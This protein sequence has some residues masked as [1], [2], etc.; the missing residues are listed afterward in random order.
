MPHLESV[1]H[2]PQPIL[3]HPASIMPHLESNQQHSKLGSGN[4]ASTSMYLLNPQE[5]SDVREVLQYSDSTQQNSFFDSSNPVQT[6]LW[7]KSAA[8]NLKGTEE[9]SVSTRNHSISRPIPRH[10]SIAVQ[11]SLSN[12]A[13]VKSPQLVQEHSES[14]PQDLAPPQHHPVSDSQH[15]ITTSYNSELAPQNLVPSQ[16]HLTSDSQFS[17]TILQHPQSTLQ[18]P[19]YPTHYWAPSQFLLPASQYSE[20][21]P[22]ELQ[23]TFPY[24]MPGAQP[25][26][27]NS[28]LQALNS[29]YLRP[30]FLGSVYQYQVS[31][32]HYLAPV[33]QSAPQYAQPPFSYYP[34]SYPQNS[35]LPEAYPVL[36]P[37]P[38]YMVSSTQSAVPSSTVLEPI[39]INLVSPSANSTM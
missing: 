30:F 10:L 16:H 8:Q 14:P 37:L 36:R 35:I 26:T 9:Y 13:T 18:H 33:S 39:F 3:N 32:P 19:I 6:L 4:S 2:H 11:H 1:V 29:Q 28:Q 27:P 24:L 22:R 15:P 17:Q 31:S 21:T 7:S 5:H 12:S 25:W 20:S 23:S 34:V 38:Q